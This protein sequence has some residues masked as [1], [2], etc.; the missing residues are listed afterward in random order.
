LDKVRG[1]DHDKSAY[2][3]QSAIASAIFEIEPERSQDTLESIQG[4]E[5][6]QIQVK[7]RA[8]REIPDELLSFDETLGKKLSALL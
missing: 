3:T 8:L 2:S 1:T 4:K 5:W 7:N 6:L